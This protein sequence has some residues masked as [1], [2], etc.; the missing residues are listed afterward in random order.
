MRE[1]AYFMFFKQTPPQKNIVW[2]LLKM[3][4][5]GRKKTVLQKL[6]VNFFSFVSSASHKLFSLLS[7]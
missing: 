6:S 2:I 7:F 1:V 4:T 3:Q 5:K